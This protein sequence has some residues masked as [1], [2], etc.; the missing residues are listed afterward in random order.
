[1][2]SNQDMAAK[3]A[4]HRLQ[5]DSKKSFKRLLTILRPHFS[6][7]KIS[8]STSKSANIITKSGR[9]IF[10]YFHNTRNRKYIT[11]K[12]TH[13]LNCT[14]K[15]THTCKHTD[16]LQTYTCAN[17]FTYTMQHICMHTFSSIHVHT[18]MYTCVHTH[19]YI[20]HVHAQKQVP[21]RYPTP[22]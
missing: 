5:K 21:K 22:I 19:S 14:Y 10:A 9:I 12:Y 4:I 16:T 13:T 15:C 7:E 2:L 17:T 20:Q 6:L 11:H 1:M 18:W 3:D 8:I